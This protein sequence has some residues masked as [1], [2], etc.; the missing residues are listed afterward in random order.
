MIDAHVHVARPNLPG[1]GSLSPL[2][3]AGAENIAAALRDEMRAAGVRHVLAMGSC[4]HHLDD[5]LG[6]DGTLEVARH[7]PGSTPSAWPTRR[8]GGDPDHCAASRPSW[9]PAAFGR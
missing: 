6:V 4:L 5:P 3:D 1:A 2:M 8:G 7:V 9:P